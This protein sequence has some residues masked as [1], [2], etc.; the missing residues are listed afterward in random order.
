[1]VKYQLFIEDLLMVEHHGNPKKHHI[2]KANVIS[3]E[4]NYG[5]IPKLLF[6][7]PDIVFTEA[8]AKE[9]HF[10]TMDARLI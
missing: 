7:I 4:V 1:M 10:L 6:W 3:I 5:K 8:N 2:K 9:L